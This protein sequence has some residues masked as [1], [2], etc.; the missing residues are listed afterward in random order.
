MARECRPVP[1]LSLAQRI[2]VDQQPMKRSSEVVFLRIL[3]CFGEKRLL[4]ELAH[5]RR[6]QAL[7]L[8]QLTR[9][10]PVF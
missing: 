9:A 10:Q 4:A 3:H 8:R 2:P 6:Y 1:F 7:A 5:W